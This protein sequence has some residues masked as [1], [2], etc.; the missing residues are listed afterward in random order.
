MF[1]NRCDLLTAYKSA[2]LVSAWGNTPHD[3]SMAIYHG[4][5]P[6]KIVPERLNVG[7]IEPVRF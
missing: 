3:K 1:G 2:P 6:I 4:S 5:L 7:K